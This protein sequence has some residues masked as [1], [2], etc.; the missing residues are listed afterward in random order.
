MGAPRNVR[1]GGVWRGGLRAG[2]LALAVSALLAGQSAPA[3]ADDPLG[4]LLQKKEQLERAVQVSRQHAERYRQA[5]N[6]YDAAV[7]VANQRIADLADKMDAAQSEADALGFKIEIAQEQLQLVAFQLNETRTLA[8][9]LRAQAASETRLL[10]QREEQYGRHLRLT[11]RQAQVSPLEMLLSSGSLAEFATRVQAMIIVNRQDVQLA[12]EIR[13]LRESTADKLDAAATKQTE[14][15]G[16][17]DQISKQS[18]ALALEKARYDDLVAQAQGSIDQQS[19]LRGTAAVN[20]N[21]ALQQQRAASNE[22]A[23]LNR[24]L[25]QTEALYEDL[26]AQLAARSGLGAFNGSKL[27][28]W[29]IRGPITS[30]FGPRWGGFHNGLDIASPKYTPIRAAAAGQVVTVGRPYVASGDTAVVVIVAHGFNFS[31]LYGHLDD[32]RWPPVRVGQ[33]VNAGDVIGY[34]GMT[35][36]TTGPHLHFMTIAN[37]RAV[38]PFPYLP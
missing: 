23:A 15:L 32:G 25:E 5:A 3:L 1:G 35:G 36:W 37:G 8:E 28:M 4:D 31:T 30:G 12:N 20:R 10:A 33:K 14:V 26:A 34:V 2:V 19:Q 16:L 13:G 38:N 7:A 17:Q 22:T 9:S 6:Q 21:S 24:Q 27:P 18:A 11:Y 29:P